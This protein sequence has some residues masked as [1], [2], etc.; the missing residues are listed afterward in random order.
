MAR[1]QDAGAA[2]DVASCD[3]F[4]L[5]TGGGFLLP[6]VHIFSPTV[7]IVVYTCIHSKRF[8]LRKRK[9]TNLLDCKCTGVK[10]Y[11]E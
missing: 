8:C 10:H 1:G 9:P 11:C 6:R 7:C 4:P 5:V 2:P 3:F